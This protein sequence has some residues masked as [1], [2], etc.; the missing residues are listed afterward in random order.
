[1]LLWVSSRVIKSLHLFLTTQLHTFHYSVP[2][3]MVRKLLLWLNSL[4]H[5]AVLT[6]I[7][8]SMF[9]S[10][11]RNS[12]ASLALSETPFS[13][14]ESWHCR[15][16]KRKDINPKHLT[17][18]DAFCSSALSLQD[19]LSRRESHILQ[20]SFHLL[21]PHATSLSCSTFQTAGHA[22]ALN[23]KAH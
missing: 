22:A 3:M 17:S 15:H 19:F 6:W 10:W 9:F 12:L 11:T 13:A 1:M 8:C 14:W 21:Q 2:N 23:K 18:V 5:T 7:C 16:T 20:D 4:Y